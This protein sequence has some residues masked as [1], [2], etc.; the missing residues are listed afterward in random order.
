MSRPLPFALAT[1]LLVV[2]VQPAG[3]E[4]ATQTRD[5]RSGCTPAWRATFGQ[6]RGTNDRVKAFAVFDDGRGPALY[7]GGSFTS[8]GGAPANHI[9]RWDGASW[10]TLGSGMNDEVLCLAVFDDGR[11]PALYAG[12]AFTSA[13]DV[14]VEHV[15][16]WNGAGFEP[17]AAGRND[18]VRAL[19]VYDDASGAGPALI[20]GGGDVARWNGVGWS[21]LGSAPNSSVNAFTVHDDGTGIEL[22]AG[23]DFTLIGGTVASHVA[24]WNGSRW[25]A[26]GVG[27]NGSVLALAPYDDGSGAVPR[28]VA[29]G[30]L[31]SPWGL[32]AAWDGSRWSNLGVGLTGSGA[33]SVTALTSFDDGV[34]SQAHLFVG[35][36]FSTSGATVV[37]PMARWSGTRWGQ[38]GI[39]LSGETVLALA[40]FDDGRGAGP[41]L[42]AGG[43][44][45]NSP[46]EFNH[47][48]R[49]DGESWTP[50]GAGFTRPAS[51]EGFSARVNALVLHDDGAGRALFVGGGFRGHADELFDGVARFDGASLSPLA[52]GLPRPVLALASFDDGTGAALYAGQ[53]FAAQSLATNQLARWNGTS[54][55]NVGDPLDDDL[56]SLAVF[57][58]GSGSALYAGGAFRR[59]T[60]AQGQVALNGVAKWEAGR[61][62]PLSGGLNDSVWTLAVFDDGAGPSLY[63][64]GRF[65]ESGGVPMNRVARWDGVSWS[66]L[67]GGVLGDTQFV[68]VLSLAVFDDGTGPALYVGGIFATAE[69][70]SVHNVARWD[71]ASWS[72]LGTGTNGRVFALTVFDDGAG[73]ALLAGGKFTLAG[74]VPAAGVARWDGAL[75]SALDAGCGGGRVS[76]LLGFDDGRDPPALYVGGEFTTSPA[77]DSVLARW[78]GCLDVLPPTLDCP[79]EVRV[80]DSF[81]DAGEVVGFAVVATDAQDPAPSVVCVPPSGSRFPLGTTLVT[82]TATDAAGNRATCEFPV[83]I[84]RKARRR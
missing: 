60:R 39:G 1:T 35:G 68:D 58:D 82:C 5:L 79:A 2:P 53:D 30:T 32:V 71:G 66:P 75:W 59:T 44:F 19:A 6:E 78:Q 55:A 52:G 76:C 45:G 51:F 84:E 50:L 38:V 36:T 18:I 11:G 80:L 56:H 62:Q 43:D 40:R 7:A 27:V 24:K 48:A 37:G 22:F 26:L 64:G 46:Q 65:T 41:A 61:W 57:D 21:S 25:A 10:T 74:D 8:A 28:L 81:A 47:V 34:G 77:G 33:P 67:G 54:W 70:S 3:D 9:A 4:L 23:G 17:L 42:F 20:A 14:S 69:G 31:G 16:R 12:G 63:A 15:A 83:T 72:P 73:P 29:G 49:W 13:G